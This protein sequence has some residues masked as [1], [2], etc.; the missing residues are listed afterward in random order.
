M[1]HQ[2]ILFLPKSSNFLDTMWFSLIFHV[3]CL[4]GVQSPVQSLAL[5]TNSPWFVQTG[6]NLLD[7]QAHCKHCQPCA[8]TDRTFYVKRSRS[9]CQLSHDIKARFCR[10][11]EEFWK[12][13][14]FLVP[15]LK[16]LL[17]ICL[18]CRQ[19]AQKYPV[20]GPEDQEFV[21]V[22]NVVLSASVKG[23]CFL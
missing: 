13:L 22:R 9:S 20:A 11:L 16:W 6:W 4:S 15:W 19:S 8:I 14:V 21:A 2:T 17:W 1:L 7:V 12:Q 10:E 3:R 18:T 23:W 5:T